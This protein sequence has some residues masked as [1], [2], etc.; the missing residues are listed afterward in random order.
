MQMDVSESSSLSIVMDCSEVCS[1]LADY[2][3]DYYL[4]F[5]I[6]EL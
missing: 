4:W 1:L 6:F 5:V 3:G 2:L